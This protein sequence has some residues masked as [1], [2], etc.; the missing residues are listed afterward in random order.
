MTAVKT[1]RVVIPKTAVQQWRQAF[2]FLFIILLPSNFGALYS[3]RPQPPDLS[4]RET[5]ENKAKYG[6]AA[7]DKDSVHMTMILK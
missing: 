2:V 3:S 5:T 7:N 6:Q 1:A 4:A